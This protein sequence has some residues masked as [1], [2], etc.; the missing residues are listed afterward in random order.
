MKEVDEKVSYVEAEFKIPVTN[1]QGNEDCE[2]KIET[3][4]QK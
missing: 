4:M 3:D 1:E 2:R